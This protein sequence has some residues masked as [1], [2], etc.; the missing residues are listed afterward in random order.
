MGP[1]GSCL[2][3]SSGSLMFSTTSLSRVLPGPVIRGIERPE[4]GCGSFTI[5]TVMTTTITT[6]PDKDQVKTDS[7][8]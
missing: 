8:G 5:S 7:S 2:Q 6:I 3:A 4:L 1:L